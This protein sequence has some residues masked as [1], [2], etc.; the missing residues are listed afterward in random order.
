[1]T[2]ITRN[3][4]W[5]ISQPGIA[6]IGQECYTI[7]VENLELSDI[8]CL[9][10]GLSKGLGIGIVIGGS[11]MKLPQVLLIVRARSS[12]GLSLPSYI[13]ESVAYAINL[14]YSN[15][16]QFPFSTYGENL[17]LTMQNAL[18]N[19]LIIAY[20]PRLRLTQTPEDKRKAL[21]AAGGITCLV[22]FLLWTLPMTILA[23]LQ[24][25]TLPLSILS[26]FPQIRQNARTSS[27]GQLSVF[28]VA[29]QVVGCLARLFTTAMEVGDRLVAASYAIALLLNVVLGVQ[30]WLY[31]G[32]EDRTAKEELPTS[33][34][35]G[36]PSFGLR[37]LSSKILLSLFFFS[38][39]TDALPPVLVM[40]YSKKGKDFRASSFPT[41]K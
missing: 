29:S 19:L 7:L 27:T 20:A 14:A 35:P 21:F 2:N 17:F 10:Y 41:K 22:A 16:N 13:M 11:I 23:L 1:M 40:P 25:S 9:K 28:A 18:I 3:F 30:I 12:R 32:K 4:P 6:I 36:R 26:K 24:A 39:V 5:F 31:W 15:R 8:K 38:T 34:G 33:R 37:I